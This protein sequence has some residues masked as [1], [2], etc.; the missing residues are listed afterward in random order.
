LDK[1][2]N[3]ILSPRELNFL[4]KFKKN[5]NPISYYC[6]SQVG[7]VTAA[8]SFFIINKETASKYELNNFI[9]PIIQKGSL[10]K[11]IIEMESGDFKKISSLNQPCYLLSLKDGVEK[12]FPLN[13]R[14]Y[15]KE[16]KRQGIPN[17][18]KCKLRNNWYCVPSI[19]GSDGLFVKRTDKL[20]KIIFNPN[21]I[22]ATDSFYRIKMR[23]K[24][25]IKSLSFSF[26]NTLTFI[27]S[28]L[29]GRFY[30]GGVLELTPNEF[31]NLPI[32]YAKI[33]EGKFNE[34][35]KM[36]RNNSEPDSIRKFIDKIVLEKELRLSKKDLDRLNSIYN[37]LVKRRLKIQ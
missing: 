6:N 3:Y 29:E 4:D 25:D 30:G 5:L 34:F 17:R 9:K 32:P 24:F 18:Y 10:L 19:W 26:H 35:D 12:D 20:P 37:K 16:G 22:L 33:T 11:N 27:F 31:K 21:K 23:S 13:I 2:T 1:W 7:I 14:R 15:F 8:N 36:Y 28:E